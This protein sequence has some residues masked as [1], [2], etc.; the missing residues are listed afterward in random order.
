MGGFDAGEAQ[1]QLFSKG[2]ELR[3]RVLGQAHVAAD[4]ALDLDSATDLRQLMT[5]VGW[6]TIWQRDGFDLRT[7][8]LVTVAMLIALNRPHELATHFRGALNNGATEPELRET[9][10]QA[11][12]YCG[13][14]AAIDADRVLDEVFL[15]RT[16]EDA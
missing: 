3:S 11:I 14:P 2:V 12:L 7:R 9:V 10:I 16:G 15:R 1:R 8:S 6:G 5:T 13:F 4:G